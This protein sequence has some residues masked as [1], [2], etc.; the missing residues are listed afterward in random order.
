MAKCKPRNRRCSIVRVRR[1]LCTGSQ[2]GRSPIL[3]ERRSGRLVSRRVGSKPTPIGRLA[4]HHPDAVWT[5]R[6]HV[7]DNDLRSSAKID[8]GFDQRVSQTFFR[9]RLPHPRILMRIQRTFT[10]RWPRRWSL[11]LVRHTPLV[12]VESFL[13]ALFTVVIGL[14]FYP[15]SYLLLGLLFF[16]L[17]CFFLVSLVVLSLTT[18]LLFGP[19][20]RAVRRSFLRI[21]CRRETG[22]AGNGLVTQDGRGT[23]REAGDLWDR[24]LDG[25]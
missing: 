20:V 16:L 17:G 1:K 4:R 7:P 3:G 21:I 6:L 22:K 5:G 10:P 8:R 18:F 15:F 23:I 25:P 9:F 11:F 19:V 24:W 12:V 13:L 2:S 14:L